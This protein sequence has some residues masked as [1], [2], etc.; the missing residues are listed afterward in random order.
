[1]L[2]LWFC[3]IFSSMALSQM[4]DRAR[5]IKNAEELKTYPALVTFILKVFEPTPGVGE[6]EVESYPAPFLLMFYSLI[7][8][9]VSFACLFGIC[10]DEQY[11]QILLS[12]GVLPLLM[13]TW[14]FDYLINKCLAKRFLKII[15]KKIVQIILH[16]P[17]ILAIP[18]GVLLFWFEYA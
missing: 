15:R 3:F 17:I 4:A 10:I 13:V 2:F 5:I 8:P 9:Y 7:F 11:D 12:V 6:K 16:I 14:V 1:M 18:L